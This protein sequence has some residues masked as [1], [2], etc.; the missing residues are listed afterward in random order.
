[1][2]GTKRSL[3]IVTNLR[4]AMKGK[5]QSE[6]PFVDIEFLKSR[7]DITGSFLKNLINVF[8][9]EAPKLI[10][11]LKIRQ[12]LGAVEDVKSLGHKLKGMSLNLG[13]LNL[14]EVGREI[15]KAD[16]KIV[17]PIIDRLDSVFEKTRL[18]LT[19]FEDHIE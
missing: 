2:D 10:A 6:T 5:N 1:L 8:N 4:L 12:Q 9:R 18:V 19:E 17:S 13:A 7:K 16:P 15:E 14:S 3:E 11:E